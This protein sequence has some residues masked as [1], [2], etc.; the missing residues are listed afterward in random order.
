M[1]MRYMAVCKLG[2]RLHFMYVQQVI[3]F[4]HGSLLLH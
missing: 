3:Q 1:A 4:A 2:T